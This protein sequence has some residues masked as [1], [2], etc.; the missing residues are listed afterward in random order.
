VTEQ[1][2]ARPDVADRFVARKHRSIRLRGIQHPVTTYLIEDVA[3]PYKE[4]FERQIQQLWWQ[5]HRR[6]G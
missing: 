1:V 3:P 2:Y 4:A 5:G 6:T